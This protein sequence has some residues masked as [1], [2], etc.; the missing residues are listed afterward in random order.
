[1]PEGGKLTLHL[2]GD[3]A[4]TLAVAAAQKA[5]G[6]AKNPAPF[7]EPGLLHMH[8]KHRW[9]R[10]PAQIRTCTVRK[11]RWL[12]EG[13]P[14]RICRRRKAALVGRPVYAIWCR[15]LKWLRGDALAETDT[16]YACRSESWPKGIRYLALG[17]N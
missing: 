11:L 8:R 9:L 16:R 5:G 6:S 1:M 2:R 15:N 7:Q 13:A 17:R 3:L 4:G 12:R 10:G 14:I